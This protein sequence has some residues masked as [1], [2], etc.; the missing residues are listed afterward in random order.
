[1]DCTCSQASEL[2]AAGFKYFALGRWIR[3]EG[4][5]PHG[6]FTTEE[7]VAIVAREAALL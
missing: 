6:F 7:A 3:V 4:P 5:A 1:M 2:K